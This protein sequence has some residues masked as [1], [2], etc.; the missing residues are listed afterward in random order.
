MKYNKI[1]RTLALALILFLLLVAI[2]ATPALAQAGY[3]TLTPTSGTIGTTVTIT[4][5]GFT[6]YVGTY[7]FTSSSVI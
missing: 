1:F 2:P 4:G 6:G 5:I 7:M 3:I